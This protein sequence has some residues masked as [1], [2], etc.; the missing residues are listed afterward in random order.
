MPL[1]ALLG[2]QGAVFLLTCARLLGISDFILCTN[3]STIAKISVE[4]KTYYNLN[5]GD[6]DLYKIYRHSDRA[7]I[8]ET[9]PNFRFKKGPYHSF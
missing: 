5:L 4:M 8:M 6:H 1:N 2:I 3:N 7:L 9:D